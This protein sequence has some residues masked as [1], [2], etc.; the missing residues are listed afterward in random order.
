MATNSASSTIVSQ[1][2]YNGG[3]N[4]YGTKAQY[5]GYNG[6][7]YYTYILK[8]TTP[9][10]GG[11][12][13]DLTIKLGMNVIASATLI[14]NYALCT[15]DANKEKYV[16]TYNTVTDATQ[17]AAGTVTLAE[18]LTELL[19][20][21]ANLKAATTYYL[22]LWGSNN[23]NVLA[24]VGVTSGHSASVSYNSGLVYIDSGRGFEAYTAHIDNGTGW[25]MVIPYV[26]SGTAWII[27]A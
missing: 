12:S 26:D 25:D 20:S 5:V 1:S 22:Y 13:E 24:T 6:G 17:I 16:K 27:C 23:K 9:S 18:P 11:I 14:L 15:S 2:G 21:T 3:W 19:I 10:F 7:K 4:D 8:F